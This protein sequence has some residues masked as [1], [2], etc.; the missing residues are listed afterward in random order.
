MR[1]RRTSRTIGGVA[2][3]LALLLAIDPQ[4]AARTT[5]P[6]AGG[7]IELGVDDKAFWE[8]TIGGQVP[9]ALT[10]GIG[11]VTCAEY[12]IDVTEDA[13]R[14]RVAV[15]RPSSLGP[16]VSLSL[17][18]PTGAER[19][20]V[21][22]A[23]RD[24]AQRPTGFQTQEAFVD[25]PMTGE[26][27]ARVATR[28]ETDAAPFRMRAKL[29]S[30]PR[31]PRHPKRLLP[32]LIPTP[33]YE[34]TFSNPDSTSTGGCMQEE[35]DTAG[36]RL[37][38]RFSAGPMNAGDG[39]LDLAYDGV[40]QLEGDITQRIHWSDGR[41]EEVP[42]GTFHYHVE[43]RHYHHDSIG[44]NELLRVEPD[45]SLT[46]V[47]LTPKTGYCMGDYF[48]VNWK[49]FDNEPP[50]TVPEQAQSCGLTGPLGANLGLA[51]GWGDEYG[52]ATIG[53]YVEF[54]GAGDGEYVVRMASNDDG[55]IVESSY[56]DNI[57]Y[58]HFT[59]TGTTIEVL[60]RGIGLGPADPTKQVITDEY[61]PLV[62]P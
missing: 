33:P 11:V 58:T 56:D 18:D 3:G 45:G 8:G 7:V 14:L 37:C 53:N 6:D 31:Q 30:E 59:V 40:G 55:N 10:C 19:T 47:S 5:A 2:A 12:R 24:V 13:W 62:G 49:S 60:E 39:V 54:E 1:T 4:V 27:I 21:D 28:T 52:W 26:W 20:T 36:A 9:T 17:V 44:G 32:N 16:E 15:E 23:L 38:L 46:R 34:L 50:R 42:G 41:I 22:D 61:R 29:E 51:V 35:R 43:H 57:A 48:V 25:R